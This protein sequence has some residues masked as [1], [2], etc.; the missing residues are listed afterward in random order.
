MSDEAFVPALI[1]G[2][3]YRW[4]A[5]VLV[6]LG[7]FLGTLDTSIVNIALPTLAKEFNVPANEAI[8]VTLIFIVVSTGLSLI[9][10]RLGDLYG[11]KILY[12]LGFTLFMI[13][14]GFSALSASLPEL[15]GGRVIQ[16]IGASMV[17]SNGAAIL[18][19]T[20]PVLP[21]PARKFQP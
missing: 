21:T 9:M 1:A 12:T 18:T 13:A 3:P 15:L 20:F 16:A 17:I 8:W 10:A 7:V 6:C 11:R 19:S 14:A 4:V 2:N 5:L